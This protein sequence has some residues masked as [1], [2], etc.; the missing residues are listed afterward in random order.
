MGW[1]TASGNLP[2]CY[3]SQACIPVALCFAS[4]KWKNFRHRLLIITWPERR[5]RP[6]QERSQAPWQPAGN[7][8][9]LVWKSVHLWLAQHN[10]TGMQAL[11]ATSGQSRHC[12]ASGKFAQD[13]HLEDDSSQLAFQRGA[14]LVR[15]RFFEQG[16]DPELS[17]SS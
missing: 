10:A 1:Q 9:Q 17:A 12:Q 6:L 2:L 16:A 7:H 14:L 8:Q 3:L 13:A 4:H 11:K 15:V 5:G